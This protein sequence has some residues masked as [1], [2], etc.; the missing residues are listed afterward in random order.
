MKSKKKFSH[1]KSEMTTN[2]YLL[3]TLK[4]LTPFITLMNLQPKKIICLLTTRWTR[5]RAAC[6]GTP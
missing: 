4:I 5:R 3:G 6:P 2:F 1:N